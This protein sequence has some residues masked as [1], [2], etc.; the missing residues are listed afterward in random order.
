MTETERENA[1]TEC[2]YGIIEK[3]NQILRYA[4]NARKS[5]DVSTVKA[6]L[7]NIQRTS[8]DIWENAD[9]GL[10]TVEKKGE[11]NDL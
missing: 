7:K 8:N 10:S 3:A 6:A 4:T 5:G 9:D 1:C 2:L 11:K